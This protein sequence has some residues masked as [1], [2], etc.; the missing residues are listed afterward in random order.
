ME[1]SRS[2]SGSCLT[3]SCT[4]ARIGAACY[5]SVWQGLESSGT[6]R[7]GKQ[8]G[9]VGKGTVRQALEGIGVAGYGEQRG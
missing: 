1:G 8:R 4:E 9:S 3:R 5:G 2:T 6:V 7:Q